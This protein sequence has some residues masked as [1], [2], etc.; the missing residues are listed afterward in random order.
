[1]LLFYYT[2]PSQTSAVILSLAYL[3]STKR[4]LRCGIFLLKMGGDIKRVQHE[5]RIESLTPR[6]KSIVVIVFRATNEK[7]HRIMR[8]PSGRNAFTDRRKALYPLFTDQQASNQCHPSRC[9]LSFATVPVPNLRIA[10]TKCKCSIDSLVLHRIV[11]FHHNF[12][13]SSL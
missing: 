12:R 8:W 5:E 2:S 9:A 10:R 1:M 13:R 6:K 11:N 7:R 3:R 4:R